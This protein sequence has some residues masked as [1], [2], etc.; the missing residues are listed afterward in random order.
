MN[1]LIQLIYDRLRSDEGP[2]IFGDTGD[3]ASDGQ[4]LEIAQNIAEAIIEAGW[5]RT[6]G[7]S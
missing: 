2:E 6:G 5:P 4:L 1:D 7:A 3:L